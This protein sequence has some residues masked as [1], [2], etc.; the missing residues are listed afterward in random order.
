MVGIFIRDEW[1]GSIADTDLLTR[2]LLSG[3]PV[4]F[5]SELGTKLGSFKPEVQK[6]P[7]LPL[8]PWD[9]SITREELDRRTA[10]GGISFEEVKARL[11]WETGDRD[12]A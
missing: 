1:I 5:R 2:I 3:V 6:S 8:V 7:T 12:V 10:E 9:P 4:E 11:G